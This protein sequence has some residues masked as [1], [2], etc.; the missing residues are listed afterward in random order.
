MASS[1]N[2]DEEPSSSVQ[3]ATTT[4]TAHPPPP[5]TTATT[6]TTVSLGGTLEKN[7]A[8]YAL[9]D[10][11]LHQDADSNDGSGGG[12]NAG[13]GNSDTVDTSKM[14][15]ITIPITY[16]PAIIGRSHDSNEPNF[17]GLGSNK[18]ISRKQCTIHY[19]D[20]DGGRVEWD[21]KARVEKDEN[22]DEVAKGQLV[23]LPPD[24]VRR[25]V[26]D[27]AMEADKLIHNSIS[28][29]KD[30]AATKAQDT[31][32]DDL[33][34][35]G[36]F[37]LECL[38]K[39]RLIVDNKRVQ[40]GH[41]IVLKNGST[42]RISSYCLYFFLPTDATNTPLTISSSNPEGKKNKNKNAKK[43]NNSPKK[44]RPA[45]SSTSD[46]P[47]KKA[48]STT[49]DSTAA[50]AAEASGGSTIN[51]YQNELDGMSSEELLSMFNDAMKSD[52]WDR[53]TQLLGSSICA[54]AVMDA[55]RG[56]MSLARQEGD[57]LSR[58]E[59]IDWIAQSERYS[60]WVVSMHEKMESRSYVSSITRSLLRIGYVRNA[61]SGRYIRWIL[62]DSILS[63]SDDIETDEKPDD[64]DGSEDAADAKGKVQAQA[65]SNGENSPAD[66]DAGDPDAGE[67]SD[68]EEASKK[69]DNSNTS[70]H[71]NE[72]VDESDGG[73]EDEDENLSPENKIGEQKS[74]DHDSRSND[75]DDGIESRDESKD[76]EE[77]E[78]DGDTGDM[79]ED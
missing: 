63:N 75:S 15:R 17:F 52:T 16:L 58:K 76:Q 4:T 67:T 25:Q 39:N 27:D 60:D 18:A 73:S 35:R 23:Y 13:A 59:I 78:E 55:G 14:E 24:K 46:S 70:S 10:G 28:K 64:P 47:D 20:A 65:S 8:A 32:D 33:P 57:S 19:R 30:A 71:E 62:P 50:A 54:R 7:D 1:P 53:R 3:A 69:G 43:K 40:Q 61:G 29:E 45:T 9:L 68:Q 41:S 77:G 11:L 22:G 21:P 42:I 2:I 5:P 79:E 66:D 6:T 74:A 51:T 36:F 26:G 37:V 34:P 38:G 31:T 72:P 49:D 12:G 48:K 44:K 56:M